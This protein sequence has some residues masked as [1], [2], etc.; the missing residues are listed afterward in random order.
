MSRSYRW[1]PLAG[2][3]AIILM[4]VAFIVGGSSPNADDS[5]SK[6]AAYLAKDSEFHRNVVALLLT[7]VAV[8]LIVVF[9][10]AVRS[11]LA[12][13][14]RFA[15]HA[16]LAFA[17]GTV[18]AVFLF[19]A[20]TGFAVS[21]FAAHDARPAAIDPTFYRL[22]NDTGYAFWLAAGGFGAIAAWATAAAILRGALLPRWFGWVS[23]VAGVGAIAAFAFFPMFLYGL[24]ILVTGIL[25]AMRSG[26]A[27]VPPVAPAPAPTPAA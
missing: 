20:V 4:V 23:V 14:V 2:A 13:D 24:W 26:P 5:D 3:L 17:A 18:S 1:G 16:T 22:A 21:L 10:A 15:N 11:R 12:I 7:L 19:M 9:Y 25:L 8:M 27:P 6:I